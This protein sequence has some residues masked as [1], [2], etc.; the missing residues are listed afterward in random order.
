M[1]CSAKAVESRLYRAR[2][3][4]RAALEKNFAEK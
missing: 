2:Q 1:K 4:L 3:H